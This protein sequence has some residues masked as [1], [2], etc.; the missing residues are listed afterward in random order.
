MAVLVQQ[1]EG[2][3]NEQPADRR[4]RLRVAEH[5]FTLPGIGKQLRQPG[6]GSDEFHAD[7]DERGAAKD[8]QHQR[9]G[10]EP[11]SQC[12]KGIQQDAP[13]KH[14][15]SA[16]AVGQIAAQEPERP[17]AQSA[18]PHDV[19]VPRQDLLKSRFGEWID[20]EQLRQG[21]LGNQRHHEQLID[22]KCKPDGRDDAD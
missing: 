15:S 5:C 19:G 7:A 12:R 10:A 11:S 8:K 13:G 2:E 4:E 6:D 22:V 9:A 21:R 18:P 1:A 20:L 14:P 16:E 3:G 17:A